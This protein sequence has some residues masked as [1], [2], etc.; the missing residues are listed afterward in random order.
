[1]LDNFSIP[2]RKATPTERM[3]PFERGRR[4]VTKY[5]SRLRPFEKRRYIEQEGIEFDP[6]LPDLKFDGTVYIDGLWQSENYF[7]DYES[8]IRSD[9][10]MTH[11]QD[12]ENRRILQ[13]IES[14]ESVAVHFRFFDSPDSETQ[15]HNIGMT[16]YSRACQTISHRV[17]SPHFFVFSDNPDA[18][19]KNF[20]VIQASFTIVDVNHESGND[21]YDFRLMSA[22]RHFIIA[23]STFSWWGAWLGKFEKKL[24]IA[25]ANTIR[26]TGITA[27][28]FAGLIPERWVRV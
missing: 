21:F 28:G 25:P 19:R 9:L 17:A 16:Y 14:S 5:V 23:N 13:S 24:V 18:A 22:C 8:Q 26:S 7:K 15:C 10:Q 12:E 3:E 1:M 20:E 11:P 2:C 4:A 6:R 27:W